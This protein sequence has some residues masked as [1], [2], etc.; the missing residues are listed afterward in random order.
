MTWYYLC[1]FDHKRLQ[2]ELLELHA[3]RPETRHL[4][5][6]LQGRAPQDMDRLAL[7]DVAEEEG[8]AVLGKMV[9]EWMTISRDK[10]KAAARRRAR[11][12]KR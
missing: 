11:A 5:L 12:Q 4:R 6:L 8:F 7:A 9:R 1:A 10:A 2:R 3:R